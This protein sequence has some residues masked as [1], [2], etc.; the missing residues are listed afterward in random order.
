[1]WYQQ[2]D[3]IGSPAAVWKKNYLTKNNENKFFVRNPE[4]NE[5]AP[6]LW[7]SKYKDQHMKPLATSSLPGQKPCKL[8]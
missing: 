5:D 3:Q 7:E 8:E 1:M 2:D 4:C 6:S